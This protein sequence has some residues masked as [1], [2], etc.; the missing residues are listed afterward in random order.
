M[1]FISREL[2][3]V[4]DTTIFLDTGVPPNLWVTIAIR[5]HPKPISGVQSGRY[6]RRGSRRERGSSRLTPQPWYAAAVVSCLPSSPNVHFLKN[7]CS[8]AL[9]IK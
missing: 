5:A 7:A 2:E 9:L 8:P 4:K 1:V 6:P 3:V